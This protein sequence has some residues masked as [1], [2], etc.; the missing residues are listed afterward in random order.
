[1]QKSNY[2]KASL[3]FIFAVALY[4]FSPI[5]A[6]PSM[7][8]MVGDTAI[9]IKLGLDGITS[10][11]M[12]LDEIYSWHPDLIFTSHESLWYLI[13]GFMYKTMGLWGVVLVGTLFILGTV[14]LCLKFILKNKIHP[15]ITALVLVVVPFLGGFPDY[16]VRPSATSVFALVLVISVF[17]SN[18]KKKTKVISFTLICLALGWLHGGIL[19]IFAM[20]ALLFAVIELLYKR[21]RESLVYFISLALGFVAS[22]LNPVGIRVWTF[23]LKQTGASDVWNNVSEWQPHS[24]KV[25]EA[26][27]LLLLFIGFMVDSR[28]KMFDKA[29]ITKIALISMFF[30]ATC[31]YTRFNLQLT[32]LVLMFAPEEFSILLNWM[33]EHIFKFKKP[34]VFSDFSYSIITVA[35]VVLI[36]FS[37]LVSIPRYFVTN[38]MRDVENMAAFDS[39]LIVFLKDKN[40]KRP[41]NGFNSGSWLAFY[42]I[43][44][45]I[46]NR[47]DPYMREYSGVDHIRGNMNLSNLCELD[48]FVATYHSDAIILDVAPSGSYLLDE[49]ELYASDRYRVVY[50]N[51]CV[52]N[53]TDTISV[54]WV[55]IEP[56]N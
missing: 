39:D 25:L 17:M 46:D 3:A 21:F 12:I 26:I 5:T 4:V 41:F 13:L 18:V 10:G 44:V 42:D 22:L 6:L 16:N 54:R 23:G 36:L 20:L 50:D 43:P 11:H 27:V 52:S 19:P 38:T 9:Q 7:Y 31:L 32:V 48:A 49:I 33:N 2:S 45:H 15:L 47:I 24:F 8:G 55:V 1:M 30:V 56:C 51:T 14:A 35:C 28:V 34:L 29:T 40:Y 37:G 53:I